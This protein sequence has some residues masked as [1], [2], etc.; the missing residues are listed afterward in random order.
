MSLSPL[1]FFIGH[2]GKNNTSREPCRGAAALTKGVLHLLM[3]LPDSGHRRKRFWPAKGASCIPA[4]Y[5]SASQSLCR[6]GK[7]NL[8]HVF[9]SVPSCEGVYTLLFPCSEQILLD[10]S[11]LF[12]KIQG[13][14]VAKKPS[15]YGRRRKMAFSWASLCDAVSALSS[16]KQEWEWGSSD[17]FHSRFPSTELWLTQPWAAQLLVLRPGA[18]WAGTWGGC[19]VLVTP[20]SPSFLRDTF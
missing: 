13:F 6:T 3:Y 15:R 20:Q 5:L 7:S 11:I 2:W 10:F 9:T 19:S 1:K 4:L 14:M 8:L 16:V 12:C 18:E 17:L